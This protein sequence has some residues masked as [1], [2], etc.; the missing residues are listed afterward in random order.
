M[1][2]LLGCSINCLARNNVD[3][4]T[5]ERDSTYI[6]YND[7]CI[8]NSKLIELDYTKQINNKLKTII[9][10]DSIV[11]NEYKVMNNSLVKSNNKL[12]RK[13]KIGFITAL[14]AIIGLSISLIK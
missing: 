4:S 10:N 5:G 9:Y 2:V 13:S 6:S 12:K 1:I 11:I 14:V 3:F 8:V 7:L